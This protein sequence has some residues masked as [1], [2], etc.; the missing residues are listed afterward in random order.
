[1]ASSD[2]SG[3][4]SELLQTAQSLF[5]NLYATVLEPVVHAVMPEP[6]RK[7]CQRLV[8][9]ANNSKIAK[10]REFYARHVQAL[11][12]H[13]AQGW[14]AVLAVFFFGYVG[15][16]SLAVCLLG[17]SAVAVFCLGL[18]LAS[19]G[20][21]ISIIIGVITTFIFGSTFI[22]AGAAGGAVIGYLSISVSRAT[23]QFV[24]EAVER[25]TGITLHDNRTLQYLTASHLDVISEGEEEGQDSD[26]EPAAPPRSRSRATPGHSGAAGSHRPRHLQDGSRAAAPNRAGLQQTKPDEQTASHGQHA[27]H[28]QTASNTGGSSEGQPASP[29][30]H[31]PAESAGS[32]PWGQTAV[33]DPNQ[34]PSISNTSD[35][36]RFLSEAQGSEFLAGT[37]PGGNMGRA[38]T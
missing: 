5:W 9:E 38:P 3:K 28:G 16:A 7:N 30:Q 14:L 13:T 31:Q 37:G 1:M 27:S 10:D 21:S 19:V 33:K 24:L 2:M 23:L 6:T 34:S 25:L 12:P 8:Q 17:F 29:G 26:S 11:R 22:M 18:F 35:A 20:I 36:A 15:L 4:S 32:G